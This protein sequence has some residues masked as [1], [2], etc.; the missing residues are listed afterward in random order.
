[1]K[2]YL[3]V[4]I[5][6]ANEFYIVDDLNALIIELYSY[7]LERH[8]FSVVERWFKETHK[9]FVSNSVIEEVNN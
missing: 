8:T 2:N 7:A 5:K 3:V 4:N 9:V 1:M 6:N